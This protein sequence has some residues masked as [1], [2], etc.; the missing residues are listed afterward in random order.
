M[1]SPAAY[2][3]AILRFWPTSNADG[4]PNFL[5]CERALRMPASVR[6]SIF[7]SRVEILVPAQA[8]DR[9]RQ[10]DDKEGQHEP[11]HRHCGDQISPDVESVGSGRGYDRSRPHHDTIPARVESL[12][13]RRRTAVTIQN[14]TA[15]TKAVDKARYR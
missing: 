6:A 8:C 5:P 10:F 7:C 14:M 4:R 2:R 9:T 15:I 13:R 1:V 12:G 11:Y 3:S